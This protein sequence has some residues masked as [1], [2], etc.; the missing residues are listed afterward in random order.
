MLP[1]GIADGDFDLSAGA[2]FSRRGSFA[3]TIPGTWK[4]E[5]RAKNLVYATF[6]KDIPPLFAVMEKNNCIFWDIRVI[7][8]TFNHKPTNGCCHLFILLDQDEICE[9]C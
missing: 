4:M 9:K 2:G 1:E 3:K 7:P 6:H 5:I 8:S